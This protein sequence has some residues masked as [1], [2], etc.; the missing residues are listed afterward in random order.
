M[1]RSTALLMGG[2]TL[3]AIGDSFMGGFY[4]G[5]ID[6]TVGNIIAADAS[7]I[8][9]RYALI[10]SPKSLESATTLDN[11]ANSTAA[12]TRWDGLSATTALAALGSP[13]ATYCTGLSAPSDGGSGWYLPAMDELELLYRNLKPST[14]ANVV[15][16]ASGT[17][18]PTSQNYG[19]NPSSSPTGSAYTSSVPA[20]TPLVAFQGGGGETLQH[21]SLTQY[22]WS[23]TESTSSNGWRQ[24]MAVASAGTQQVTT[25]VTLSRV[26]PVRRLL[27]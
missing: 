24:S 27:L 16:S 15:S 2:A 13:A 22:I 11:N 9:R 25:K 5:I 18:P 17:F 6:T 4:A 26:R 7:Q 10:L 3:P 23:S 19:V 8:G 20:R 21:A 12:R 14:D 1:R